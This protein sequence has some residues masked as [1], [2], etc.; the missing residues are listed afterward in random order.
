ML[1]VHY[2]PWTGQA[3]SDGQVELFAKQMYSKASSIQEDYEIAI[4]TENVI[5]AIRVFIKENRFNHNFI[6]VRYQGQHLPFDT[7]GRCEIW[8]NGFC[9]TSLNLL[10]R[11]I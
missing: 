7:D 2:E 3:I 6:S 1:I 5:T 9:D 8:P 4:S 10:L 11:L